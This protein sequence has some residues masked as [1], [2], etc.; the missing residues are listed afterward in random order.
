VYYRGAEFCC[1]FLWAK[2]PD[3]KD[4]HK[5]MFPV[6][7]GNCLSRKAVDNWVEN[8]SQGR[9]KVTDDARPGA[10]VAE[11]AVKSFY[12][13][14]FDVLVKRRD[15]CINVGRGYVEK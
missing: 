3:A 11:T 1:A 13:A 12:A 8:L 5:E 10:E 14:G 2:G 7:G 4:I 15:K 6:Y 9:S